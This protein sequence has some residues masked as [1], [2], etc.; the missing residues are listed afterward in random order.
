MGEIGRRP[1]PLLGGVF[2]VRLFGFLLMVIDYFAGFVL[3]FR[4]HSVL[5]HSMLSFNAHRV[6]SKTDH[7]T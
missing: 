3:E 5:T 6:V 4:L 7:A 2:T 1:E